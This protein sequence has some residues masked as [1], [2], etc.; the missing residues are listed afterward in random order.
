MIRWALHY[1]P[2][3]KRWYRV[4]KIISIERINQGIVELKDLQEGEIAEIVEVDPTAVTWL[5]LVV[6]RSRELGLIWYHDL[7]KFTG[8]SLV[9][10][11]RV[12]MSGERVTVESDINRF[13]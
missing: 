11:V 5:G 10:K 3:Y 2:T 12:L 9:K 8:D 4:G 1:N 13:A 6:G 7:V